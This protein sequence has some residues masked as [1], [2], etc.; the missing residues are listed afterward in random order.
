MREYAG[1][2]ATKMERK[3]EGRE[4]GEVRGKTRNNSDR[5][6]DFEYLVFGEV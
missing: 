1:S 4:K 3:E 2:V 6:A 5:P